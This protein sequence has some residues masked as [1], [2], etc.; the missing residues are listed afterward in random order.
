M[1][2]SFSSRAGEPP[3]ATIQS[4]KVKLPQDHHGEDHDG[5]VEPRLAEGEEGQG[6]ADIAGIAEDQRRKDRCGGRVSAPW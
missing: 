2:G 4:P 5:I 3:P 1:I 6:Q